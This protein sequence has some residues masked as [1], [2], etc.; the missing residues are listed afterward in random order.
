M[1]LDASNLPAASPPPNPTKQGPLGSRGV[2]QVGPVKFVAEQSQ[3][4][5]A[6]Q[7]PPLAQAG[8][9]VGASAHRRGEGPA[10]E[11]GRLRF[12]GRRGC[13]W[14][15]Y[16]RSLPAGR[17]VR[18]QWQSASEASGVRP[19]GRARAP[20]V[21]HVGPVKPVPSHTHTPAPKGMHT[22][23]FAQA[24][25]HTVAPA[26]ARRGWGAGGAGA[27]REPAAVVVLAALV[28]QLGG[29]KQGRWP[30]AS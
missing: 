21:A 4:S 10:G 7:T 17:P 18:R 1:C 25:M 28:G 20:G 6:K 13:L 29:I 3:V 30:L 12:W 19:G 2:P 11:G 9:Q 24:G 27:V 26:W 16:R 14:H 15:Q 5:G 8:L 22:A 23:P